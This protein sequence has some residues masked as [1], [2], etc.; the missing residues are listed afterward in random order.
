[1]LSIIQFDGSSAFNSPFTSGHGDFL[2]DHLRDLNR[3]GG[4]DANLPCCQS[5]SH[6]QPL[7]DPLQKVS[8]QQRLSLAPPRRCAKLVETIGRGFKLQTRALMWKRYLSLTRTTNGMCGRRRSRSAPKA[9]SSSA[10]HS[11]PLL[12]IWHSTE[13]ALEW[14]KTDVSHARGTKSGRRP[15]RLD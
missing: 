2:G 11:G 5:F 6:I 7:F 15:S 3:T 4:G 13:C 14:K 1:M 9:D 12:S 10:R 8:Q